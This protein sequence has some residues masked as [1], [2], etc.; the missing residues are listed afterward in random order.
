MDKMERTKKNK[1][2][3]LLKT[4]FLSTSGRNVVKHTS[5]SKKKS[6]V[7]GSVVG[8]VILYGILA[9]CSFFFSLAIATGGYPEILPPIN[10]ITISA[11]CF[12]FTLL[13][14][15]GYMF[16]FKDYDLL[17]SM[18]IKISSIVLDKF[19][20]MYI[21]GLPIMLIVSACTL[22]GYSAVV[23][24]GVFNFITWIILSFIIPLIPTVI[25]SALGALIARIGA[26][27]KY[28]KAV[29]S[30]FMFAFVVLAIFA[31]PVI[32][33]FIKNEG[34]DEVDVDAISGVMD[35]SMS[36]YP[37]AKWFFDA[38]TGH[39]L[40]TLLMLAVSIGLLAAFVYIVSRYYRQINSKLMSVSTHRK[41]RIKGQKTKSKLQTI[42]FKEFR[43]FLGSTTY[44]V[45]VGMG[46]VLVVILSVGAFVAG[47]DR[48][49]SLIFKG[50]EISTQTVVPVISLMV[51][52]CLGMVSTTVCSPSLEGKNYWII[53]SLPLTAEEVYKGKMLFNMEL[54][55][56]FAIL[57]TVA[58]SISFKAGI[59]MTVLNLLAAVAGCAFST[60]FGMVCG[61]RSLNLDW[62]NEVEVIKQGKGIMTYMFPN[63]FATIIAVVAIMIFAEQISPIIVE[64][65]V[66][67]I[68]S[69]LAWVNYSQVMRMAKKGLE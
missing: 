2:L 59:V 41:S 54:T 39:I 15:N 68:F 29:Q 28:K 38:V 63:M 44:L 12:I 17:M 66:I 8:I 49:I 42:A 22:I 51:Y 23:D 25:A 1:S 62:E 57:G 50:S 52:F 5:D 61:I 27:F 13:K 65:M 33:T 67:A 32:E 18:P 30:I 58:L 45:N 37:P 6:N 24:M 40:G 14:T 9:L 46:E 56:P 47:G 7:A 16:A 43:R 20:Y 36:V 64:L 4:L 19:L 3:V 11:I 48:I 35:S 55:V 31:R 10:V 34:L 60:C 21:K 53:K 69:I 26:G